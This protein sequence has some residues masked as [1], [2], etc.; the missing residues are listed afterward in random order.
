MTKPVADIDTFGADYAANWKGILADLRANSPVAWSPHHGGFWFI[1]KYDDIVHCERTPQIFSCDNDLNNERQGGQGIRIPRNPFRIT[2]NESDP[3]EHGAYRKLEQP[4]FTHDALQIWFD[5]SRHVVEQHIDAFIDKGECDLVEALTIPSAAKVTLRLV[6]IPQDE[7]QDYMDSCLNSYLPT[8]D[9]RFPNAARA[10]VSERIEELMHQRADDP[11][12]D[13]ISA[14]VHAKIGENPVDWGMA[15]GMIQALCFGGF[16]TTAATAANAIRWL[17][18]KPDIRRRL[19]E[20]DQ[21]LSRATDEFLRYFPPLTGG[22]ARTVVQDTELR[23]QKLGK[24]DRVLLMFN[25]GNYDED[26][27]PEPDIC[28]IGRVNA[29]QHLAFGAGPHRCLGNVLGHAEVGIIIRGF[30]RRIGDY[31]IDRDREV[32]FATAGLQNGWHSIPL[33][34]SRA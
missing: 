23:G 32:K 24:G 25:S 13:V 33:T 27:F 8:T 3:P 10:R 14:L 7:W 31:R 34:F 18:D 21:Y 28:Q 6:G 17:E 16:D 12:D 11:R 19:V 1:T 4:F 26:R 9:P 30:C 22:L 29:K 20:D 15:K 2:L 5:H